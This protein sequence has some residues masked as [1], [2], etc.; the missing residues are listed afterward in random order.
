VP[1]TETSPGTGPENTV[2]MTAVRVVVGVTAALAK[3][4]TIASPL[5]QEKRNQHVL[6]WGSRELVPCHAPCVPCARTVCTV[7][8]VRA[9][10]TEKLAVASTLV[11]LPGKLGPQQPSA[12]SVG[13][14]RQGPHRHNAACALASHMTPLSS[15]QCLPRLVP[16]HT[17]RIP[18]MHPKTV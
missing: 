15:H 8:T 16:R 11:P 13:A 9:T 17:V 5:V 12:S 10:I 3:L 4:M 6:V 2:S 14:I 7:H 18:S 1:D